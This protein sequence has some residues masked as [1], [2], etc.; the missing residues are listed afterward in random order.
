[1]AKN[2]IA[3]DTTTIIES[4]NDISVD[5][6]TYYKDTVDTVGYAPNLQTTV[7]TDLVSAINELVPVVLYDNPTFNGGSI[8]LSD[9]AGSYS[10]FIIEYANYDGM[11]QSVI[12]DYPNG[13]SFTAI[14]GSAVAT[15]YVYQQYTKYTIN[16]S[17][18]TMNWSAQSRIAHNGATTVTY[19]T[20]NPSTYIRKV[21]AYK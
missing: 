8:V 21:I 3:G 16:G 7:K 14:H 19:S 17:N 18:I 2:L 13:K 20:T 6:N 1:M 5:L 4:G 10:R 9:S 15:P 12:V 11:Y